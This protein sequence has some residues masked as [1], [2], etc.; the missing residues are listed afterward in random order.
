MRVVVIGA[1]G[2]LG[3][4]IYEKF[5]EHGDQVIPLDHSVIEVK[6]YNS[7]KANMLRLNPELVINTAAMHHVERCEEEPEE[8]FLVNGIGA[9]N[10]A[11]LSNELDYTVMHISTDYVFDGL[12][13]S[14]YVESDSPN[15]LNMYGYSKLIGEYFVRTIAE[16]YYIV[17]VSGLYGI[18]PC[19][20]KGGRNFV[21]SMLT[22][23]QEGK[24]LRVVDD[25]VLTPTYTTDVAKQLV[26]LSRV[27]DY[28]LYHVTSQGACTWYE[29]AQ[30][31]FQL[32]DMKVSLARAEQ[33][34]FSTKVLRPKY[35]VL[36]NAHLKSLDLDGMPHW[37]DGLK[38]YLNALKRDGRLPKYGFNA[39]W[40]CANSSF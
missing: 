35:S 14:P 11:L 16:R 29:F 26:I 40:K 28:G 17:R 39:K 21:T 13:N 6:D 33:G 37:E 3:A 20:A 38:R 8:A 15:P 4:D 36:E 34:E 2:Q 10:I 32:T 30:K 27:Q 9:R 1:N 18:N 5:L 7:V 19:R 23:A 24:E 12:K 31:I 22:M 25:E